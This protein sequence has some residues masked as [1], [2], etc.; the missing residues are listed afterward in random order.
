MQPK[1]MEECEVD[2]EKKLKRRK[3]AD[4]LDGYFTPEAIHLPIV[5]SSF[6]VENTHKK[7]DYFV[8]FAF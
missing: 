6:F 8:S 2:S 3:K 5:S 1:S 4:K 7:P